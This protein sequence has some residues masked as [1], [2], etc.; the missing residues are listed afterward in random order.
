MKLEDDVFWAYQSKNY[1]I[2]FD[3]I[4]NL[5]LCDFAIEL[6]FIFLYL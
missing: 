6:I 4:L 5:F 1:F 3:A 2:L